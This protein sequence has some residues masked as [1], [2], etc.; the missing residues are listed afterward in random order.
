VPLR[1][2][3][4]RK[5]AIENRPRKAP[6]EHLEIKRLGLGPLMHPA[7]AC[8]LIDV[9]ATLVELKRNRYIG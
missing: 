8:V 5:A 9:R 7:Q 2:R 4:Y 3:G 1:Q 6:P